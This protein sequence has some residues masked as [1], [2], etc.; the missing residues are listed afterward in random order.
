MCVLHETH[1]QTDKPTKAYS[2]SHFGRARKTPGR[3]ATGA[4]RPAFAIRGHQ[5]S[6]WASF[7]RKMT[8]TCVYVMASDVAVKVGFSKK[9]K[10]RLSSVKAD[11]KRPVRLVFAGACKHAE[12]VA[13]EKIAH[14]R[15]HDKH[16]RGE[17]FDVDS[18]AAV[19]A[20]TT[21]ASSLGCELVSRSVSPKPRPKPQLSTKRREGTTFLSPEQYLA[22][23][24]A[25]GL[26]QLRFGALLR[27]NKDTSTKWAKGRARIPMSA[28]LLLRAMEAGF[29]T[30]E[31]LEELAAND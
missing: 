4:T 24:K 26:S 29:V 7:G 1:D 3:L 20:I 10:A 19:D 30:I 31:Q 12:A 11:E 2:A 9:P 21:A 28:A 8:D 27:Q 13:I 14:L 5:A 25:L 23:L 22:T 17:W 15:L 18:T 16:L 6:S